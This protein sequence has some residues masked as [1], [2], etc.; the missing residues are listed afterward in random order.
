MCNL[1]LLKDLSE[2]LAASTQDDLM[3]CEALAVG[4]N[5]SQVAE[6]ASVVIAGQAGMYDAR[7]VSE[8]CGICVWGDWCIWVSRLQDKGKRSAISR[9]QGHKQHTDRL[10]AASPGPCVRRSV[11]KVQDS[12]G[13]KWPHQGL[14]V[15]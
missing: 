13:A 8:D 10:M 6:R 2:A 4:C 9:L 7:G 3:A 11:F 12:S 15:P 14:F 1:T 5:H